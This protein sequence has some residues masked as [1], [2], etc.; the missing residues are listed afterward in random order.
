[1]CIRDRPIT[2]KFSDY[3]KRFIYDADFL[4]AEQVGYNKVLGH[5]NTLNNSFDVYK[6]SII[7]EYY[8]SGF[9]PQYEGIDWRS[10][11]RCV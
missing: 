10:L 6:N 7:V 4:N 11:R 9:D 8:F 3:Y 1:M 5:G 2:L